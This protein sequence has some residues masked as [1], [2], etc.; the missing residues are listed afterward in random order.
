MLRSFKLVCSPER[1]S[2][3]YLAVEF[4]VEL[5]VFKVCITREGHPGHHEPPRFAVSYTAVYISFQN[6]FLEKEFIERIY[7]LLFWI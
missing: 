6:V 5:Q 7:L 1:K 4:S 3:K 2:T